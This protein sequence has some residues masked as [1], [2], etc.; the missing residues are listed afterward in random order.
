MEATKQAVESL[1]GTLE[2]YY[3]AYGDNDYYLIVDQPE[4]V[5]VIAGILL[6]NA[7]GAV[8]L[9]TIPL[10]TPE[11]VDEAVKKTMDWRPPGQ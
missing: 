8:K 1:G 3:Y 7:S 5:N 2:T 11:E 6:A 9:K 4:N 10:I